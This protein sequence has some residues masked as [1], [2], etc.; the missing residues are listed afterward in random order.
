MIFLGV[1]GSFFGG[2]AGGGVKKEQPLLRLL[3][4]VRGL[5]FGYC[6]IVFI[7]PGLSMGKC[8]AA[9]R[10]QVA[11]ESGNGRGVADQLALLFACRADGRVSVGG[12]VGQ[13]AA[14]LI[15][16]AGDGR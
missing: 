16:E 11:L 4:F 15:H 12:E 1:A 3:F 8:L 10:V 14:D 2:V 5:S 9:D 7:S 13:G 6:R